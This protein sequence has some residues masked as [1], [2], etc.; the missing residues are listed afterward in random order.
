MHDPCDLSTVRVIAYFEDALDAVL[1]VC[2]GRCHGDVVR[3]LLIIEVDVER[4]G[5]LQRRVRVSGR[6]H[7]TSVGGSVGMSGIVVEMAGEAPTGVGQIRRF[8]C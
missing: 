1:R 6:G 8:P 3:H 7:E 4:V 5:G 2:L